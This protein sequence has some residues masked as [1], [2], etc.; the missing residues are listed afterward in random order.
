M[1]RI[2]RT[3][4]LYD[5]NDKDGNPMAN[6]ALDGII[7]MLQ[8]YYHRLRFDEKNA[9]I[10]D[11]AHIMVINRSQRMEATE[12]GSR[13]KNRSGNDGGVSQDVLHEQKHKNRQSTII[14]KRL[15]EHMAIGEL[16]NITK[17]TVEEPH[18]SYNENALW[19][20]LSR[21]TVDLKDL[22]DE[23]EE[24]R[25]KRWIM[26][27]QSGDERALDEL[28]D[29]V[30]NVGT[31]ENEDGQDSTSNEDNVEMTLDEIADVAAG[32]EEEDIDDTNGIDN[33]RGGGEFVGTVGSS[34]K[35]RLIRANPDKRTMVD[36]FRYGSEKL[37]RRN[38]TLKRSRL[39]RR[40]K[41]EKEIKKFVHDDIKNTNMDSMYQKGIDR[42]MIS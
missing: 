33:R 42:C 27:T 16:I 8:K 37:N 22:E 2:N 20:A 11:S 30:F 24:E 28:T 1:I 5:G 6:W 21:I 36:I 13:N 19:V 40:N 41:R 3:V 26:E 29:E 34:R 4:P 23:S 12:Y 17:L 10:K 14:P 35:I 31:A 9:H 38:L 25:T 32:D 7:E 39:Q 15:K 18:R